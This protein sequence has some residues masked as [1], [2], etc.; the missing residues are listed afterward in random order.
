MRIQMKPGDALEITLEDTDGKFRVD[1]DSKRY[2]GQFSIRETDGLPGN[3]VGAANSILY[4]E[5]FG[6]APRPKC[7][8]QDADSVYCVDVCQYLKDCIEA[9]DEEEIVQHPPAKKAGP[10][11]VV[12]KDTVDFETYT[13]RP[14][15]YGLHQTVE[16]I[17]GVEDGDGDPVETFCTV[18]CGFSSGCDVVYQ[19]RKE[20]NGE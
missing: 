2:P 15:C 8:G 14:P 12:L 19:N 1:Y 17:D 13:A 5:I 4:Q 16:V 7:F 18:E 6:G 9:G 10:K 11:C 3:V 20:T